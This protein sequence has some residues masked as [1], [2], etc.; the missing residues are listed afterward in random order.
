VLLRLTNAKRLPQL[1]AELAG[2][3]PRKLARHALGA[4]APPPPFGCPLQ[5]VA[6]RPG[7]VGTAAVCISMLP[8]EAH[9]WGAVSR[10]NGLAA[11]RLPA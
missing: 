8:A 11:L 10:G 2:H 4:I 9:R 3:Q 1:A 7:A 5:V 6:T